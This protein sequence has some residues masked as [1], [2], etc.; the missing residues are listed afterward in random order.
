ML[1]LDMLLVACWWSHMLLVACWRLHMV[2]LPCWWSG[3]LSLDVLDGRRDVVERLNRLGQ[4]LERRDP[5]GTRTRILGQE[6]ISH[7]FTAS[8]LL[9]DAC[10]CLLPVALLAAWLCLL[11]VALLPRVL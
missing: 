6:L 11:P 10:L 8:S 2:L 5:V 9:P 7:L 4:F 1:L 3:V